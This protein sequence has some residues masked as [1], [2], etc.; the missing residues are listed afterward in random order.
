MSGDSS[1]SGGFG[2]RIEEFVLGRGRR[3]YRRF[4]GVV[5]VFFV[6]VLCADAVWLV[7]DTLGSSVFSPALTDSLGTLTA[8]AFTLFVLTGLVQFLVI[9]RAVARGTEEVAQSADELER[10][11]T[12]VKD[13]AAEVEEL[14]DAV[15]SQP[16]PDETTTEEVKA[17]TDEIK[18]EMEGAEQA[19]SDIKDALDGGREPGPDDRSKSDGQ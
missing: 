13:A 2:A 7:T 5:V 19:A 11:A 15:G 4:L 16:E 8:V 14:S 1:S 3:W 12:E 9:G 10:T 6:V 18:G 17:Q